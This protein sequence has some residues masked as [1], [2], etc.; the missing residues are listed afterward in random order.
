[1]LSDVGLITIIILL[2]GSIGGTTN[3]LLNNKATTPEEVVRVLKY[4]DLELL[5]SVFLGICAAA[6]I[7]TFLFM[8]SST[9]LN[10]VIAPD[11]GFDASK[12]F[13]LFGYSIL[14]AVSS[15]KFIESLSNQFVK[16]TKDQLS[17]L[18]K[19]L[20]DINEA[21]TEREDKEVEEAIKDL[22]LDNVESEIV[23]SLML[24]NNK[25]RLPT[26]VATEAKAS[27]S[28]FKQA[29]ETLSDR[30]IIKIAAKNDK[31]YLSLKSIK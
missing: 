15:K 28:D 26:K 17:D 22:H 25:Y 19:E 21:L 9:L 29:V 27:G 5:K 18:N 1:M 10:D 24:N 3:Y 12:L 8:I 6:L 11:S 30:G 16:N 20:A 31:E 14:A 4:F 7:P 23:K 13:I 2:A